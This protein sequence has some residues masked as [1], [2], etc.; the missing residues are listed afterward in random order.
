MEYVLVASWT[1]MSGSS[2]RGSSEGQWGSKEAD[3]EVAPPW[4][5]P[6]VILSVF[7]KGKSYPELKELQF[8]H[9]QNKVEKLLKGNI[10]K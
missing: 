5:F 9:C 1:V 10:I 8:K 6:G 2:G 4:K 3:S 7:Q